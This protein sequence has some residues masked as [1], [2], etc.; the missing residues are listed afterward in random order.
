VKRVVLALAALTIV[1]LV[2]ASSSFASAGSGPTV[3]GAVLSQRLRVG[4]RALRPGTT[5]SGD[6]HLQGSS[7]GFTCE[8]CHFKGAIIARPRTTIA[9]ALDVNGSDIA[10][11]VTLPA[12]FNRGL[13]AAGATF[14][15]TVDLRGA[16]FD[17]SVSMSGAHFNGPVLAPVHFTGDADFS[18][19][20]FSALASFE[21]ATFGTAAN[22][23]LAT[24]LG[25]A[26]FAQANS[27]SDAHFERT[28]FD[29]TTD[30]TFFQFNGS[31]DFSEAQ[32]KGPVDFSNAEFH[33]DVSFNR[34]RFG[35][36]AA[37]V[38]AKFYPGQ[39]QPEDDFS[40]VAANG[41]LDFALATIDR[42]ADFEDAHV[43]QELSFKNDLTSI[44]DGLNFNNVLAGSLVMGVGFAV[45]AV[46]SEY[47]QSILSM[48]ES[49]AKA[50]GDLSTAND[51]HY[52][53]QVISSRGYWLP[54]RVLDLVFYRTIAGYLVRPLYP[55]RALLILAAL[56]S[57]VRAVRAA[58]R[59]AK[60]VGGHLTSAVRRWPAAFLATLALVLPQSWTSL[61]IETPPDG[62]GPPE[63]QAAVPQRGPIAVVS[64]AGASVYRFFAR[65]EVLIYRVL[66]ACALVGFANSNP[67]LRQMIDAIH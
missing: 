11:S 39:G 31:A 53:S 47:R 35:Q 34:A 6:V 51:A 12:T 2:H 64:R 62:P 3:T 7:H 27:T 26:V 15:R 60:H 9:D 45:S 4:P 65:S 8:N 19:T 30:F 29:G 23:N 40:F 20:T 67:T 5:V 10:G 17:K 57:C 58:G 14:E 59:S 16:K 63:T 28:T 50:R 61:S 37:F 41:D 54:W 49:S 22:F 1:G 55:L 21:T 13:F 43:R 46:Q 44:Q 33:H 66:F 18:L 25:D 38:A 32:F 36:D 42:A 56:M 24:F 52:E 48:I